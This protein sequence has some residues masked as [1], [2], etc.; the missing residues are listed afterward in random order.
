MEKQI[1]GSGR[2]WT[3]DR[4]LSLDSL[5]KIGW[6]LIFALVFLINVYFSF[7]GVQRAL[8]EI[9]SELATKHAVHQ[10]F[11]GRIIRL[12]ERDTIIQKR[13]EKLE[14]LIYKGNRQ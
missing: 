4:T 3:I 12:E 7:Q 8:D 13:L 6:A 2:S 11:D 14:D 9:K 10:N 1:N 5:L